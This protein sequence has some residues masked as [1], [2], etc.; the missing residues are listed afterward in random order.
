M[1]SGYGQNHRRKCGMTSK[2]HAITQAPCSQEYV[3]TALKNDEV[4]MR[5]DALDTG[6]GAALLKQSVS[7][8]SRALT[9]TETRYAQIE[10]ELLAIVFTC[11]KFKTSIFLSAMLSTWKQ[12]TSQSRK[13]FRRVSVMHLQ[14]CSEWFY[15]F[16]ATISK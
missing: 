12:T 8:A 3:T 5:Y 2:Q 4:T 11:K 9:Q 10:K 15:D 1:L 14:D 16:S 13:H 6:L 7:L